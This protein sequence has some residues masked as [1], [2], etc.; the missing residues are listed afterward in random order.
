MPDVVEIAFSSAQQINDAI[1]NSAPAA[2]D[3]ANNERNWQIW[4]IADNDRIDSG[5]PACY[6]IY[7]GVADKSLLTNVINGDICIDTAYKLWQR[8]SGAWVDLGTLKG[9]VGNDAQIT[10]ATASVNSTV[11]VPSVSVSTTGTPDNQSFDFEFFNLKG[12]QGD[13]AGF[14]TPT[15]SAVTLAPGSS[16]SASVS[17]SGTDNAKVFSFS[18]GIPQGIQGIQGDPGTGNNW[19]V[20]SA[21]T[22][23]STTPTIF[24]ST[25]IGDALVGDLYLNSNYSDDTYLGNLYRCTTAGDYTV[26]KWVY[27][28]NIRGASGSGVGD[29]TKAQYD[30]TNSGSVLDSQKLGGELPSYYQINTNGLSA[31]TTFADANYIPMYITS[32]TSNAKI[33][34]AN[35]KSALKDYFDTL[36]VTSAA[37]SS[38]ISA[39]WWVSNNNISLAVGHMSEEVN[40]IG[41]SVNGISVT[42]DDSSVA[43]VSVHGDSFTVYAE[44][45]GTCTLTVTDSVSMTTKT[46]SVTCTSVPSAVLNDNTPAQIQAAARAGIASQLWSV[47]DRI[48]IAP[49]GSVGR[50]NFDG[51]TTYY[52]YILGFDHNVSVEGNNTIHFQMA[53]SALSDGSNIAWTD[54]RYGTNTQS[55]T[56]GYVMNTTATN[57]GGWAAS[58]MRQT[59]CVQML[60]AMPSAWQDVIAGCIKWTDNTG[61]GTDDISYM[62]MTV[63]KVFL[64]SQYEVSAAGANVNSGE[65][66]YLKQY[67]YYANGNSKVK[68]SYNNGVGS[69]C[70]WWW[71][72][73]DIRYADRFRCCS[74]S[75]GSNPRYG[76]YSYGFAPAFMVA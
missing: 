56:T 51:I 24:V 21:I 28:C 60:A 12:E 15:A 39:A 3:E 47:G 22:G 61:G 53:F 34:V 52:A 13:A 18:F 29:M 38:A 49:N 37:I 33:T 48:G 35:I 8:Q 30:P 64:L 7:A 41:H 71:R 45:S 43:S 50:L 9:D 40:V 75:G 5:Q 32:S 58:Y 42:T 6:K 73:P 72:S 66:I 67:D 23:T 26:A 63:D 68:D 31:A 74:T 19:Y 16:A 14:G 1:N 10:G 62:A 36:Y 69:A 44:G 46:V 57:A 2:P 11:G 20:G 17:A 27:V 59:T 4:S 54:A 25:G 55:G 65:P 70:E 76:N